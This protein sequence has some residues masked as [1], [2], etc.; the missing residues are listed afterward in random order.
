MKLHQKG[1]LLTQLAVHGAAWDGALCSAAAAEYS[2]GE[3]HPG[4]IRLALEEL[5][6]AGLV[7]R[8]GEH[9]VEEAGRTRLSF[10]YQL[11]AFGEQRMRDTGL[12]PA[13]ARSVA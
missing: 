6:A 1:W 11:T 2:R 10:R 8:R 12:W 7:Q 13:Q 9:L 5:A 4:A 3:A